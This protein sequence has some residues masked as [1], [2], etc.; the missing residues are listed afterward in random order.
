MAEGSKIAWTDNTVNVWMGCTEVVLRRDGAR[1]PSECDA[2]YARELVT[3]RMGYNG[4]DEQH[5]LVWGNPKLTPRVETKYWRRVLPQWNKIAE[6]EGRLLVFSFSLSDWAEEHP[7]VG[8]WRAGFLDMIEQTPLLDYQLL[9]KRPQN[10]KRMVPRSWLQNWPQNVWVGT[11]A[12]TKAAWD[13]R[14]PYL[15]D[16]RGYGA[17]V[18][19]VSV[20]PHLEHFYPRDMYEH[21]VNWIITGGESGHGSDERPRIDAD[22]EW[23]REMRDACLSSSVAYF[24]KQGGGAKPGTNPEIDGR[25]WHQFPYAGFPWVGGVR[26]MDQAEIVHGRTEPGGT[27]AIAGRRRTGDA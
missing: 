7:M 3:H 15:A 17:P 10:I 14:V 23:F 1:V 2:C 16:L 11:S 27:W 19:F 18:G 20:E 25:L 12:G 8:P 26:A 22:V 4:R 9:T 13:L 5:P 24:H 6:K 21:G